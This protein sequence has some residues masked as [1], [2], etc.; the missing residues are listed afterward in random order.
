MF[1]LRLNGR[2]VGDHL[3]DPGLTQYDKRALYVTFDVTGELRA[4]ANAV[5][6]IL[7]NGRYYAMRS[8][9]PFDSMHNF[10][11][12]KLLLQI[13]VDYGDGTRQTILSDESWFLTDGG[14]IRANNEYDGEEYDARQEMSGWDEPGYDGK[15]HKAELVKAPL[16]RLQEQMIEP[17]RVTEVR[18]PVAITQPKPGMFM[19]DMGQAYYGTVRLKVAGR[20]GTRVQLRSAYALNADGTLRIQDNRS[21]KTTDIYVL[22]GNGTEIWSF[23]FRGQG[24]RYVEVTGFPGTP[25]V[26]SFE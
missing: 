5:G 11:F 16:G 8:K 4:G 18:I 6:V 1:E 15:W 9:I 24:Y 7:G 10:G 26:D 25:T 23:C 13:E 3:L 17:I 19:V 2:K 12:P 22:K 14:P 21:A 20:A